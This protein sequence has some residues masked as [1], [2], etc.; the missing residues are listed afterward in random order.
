METTNHIW[1]LTQTIEQL[2]TEKYPD[3]SATLIAQILETAA[4]FLENQSEASK[5][6][7]RQV[8]KYLNEEEK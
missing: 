7:G 6:I 3:L 1:D 8:E 4:H 5:R 2:R